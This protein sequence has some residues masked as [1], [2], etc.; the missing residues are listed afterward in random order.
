[1]SYFLIR[2]VA[3]AGADEIDDPELDER[4][5]AYTDAYAAAMIARGPTLGTDR[6]SW[7]GSIHIIDLPDVTAVRRYIDNEPY[8][9]AGGYER[10]VVRRFED[11]LGR[12]MWQT[13]RRPDEL[14]FF[15]IANG[16]VQPP[17]GVEPIVHGAL[18]DPDDDA[19]VGSAFAVQVPARDAVDALA[20]GG[21]EVLDWEFGGRR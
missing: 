15:V 17:D 21:A 4:H 18:H 13:E 16:T 11:L 1:M 12:T 5:W 19:V 7:T 20:S 3:A 10:H 14:R 9:L 2:S 8:Q 6:S